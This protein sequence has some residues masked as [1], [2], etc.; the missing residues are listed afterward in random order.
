MTNF[1]TI[2]DVA[3]NKYCVVK[4]QKI[5]RALNHPMRQKILSVIDK[6]KGGICVTDIFNELG[7]KQNISSEHLSTLRHAGLV[8]TFRDGTRIYYQINYKTLELIKS[9]CESITASIKTVKAA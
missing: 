7:L 1:I 4:T 8:T 3:I 5:L 6:N 9:Y 2:A